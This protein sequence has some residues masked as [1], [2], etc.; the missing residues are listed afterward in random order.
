MGK[1]LVFKGMT[2][3]NPLQTVTFTE[4]GGDDYS[5]PVQA[6]LNKLSVSP[7][8]SHKDAFETFYQTLSTANL[9]D[10]ISCLYPM[11]GSVADCA[12]GLI[13]NDIVIPSGATYDQGIDL[14]NASGGFGGMEKGI[15]LFD[16][17]TFPP[18]SKSHYCMF[19]NYPKGWTTS[20]RGYAIVFANNTTRENGNAS[21]R[22]MGQIYGDNRNYMNFT[23]TLGGARFTDVPEGSKGVFG[24][25]HPYGSDNKGHYTYFNGQ[26]VA[27]ATNTFASVDNMG[28]IGIN[29][30][31]QFN[32]A[33]HCLN[34][35]ISMVTICDSY[36]F[37]DEEVATFTTAVNNLTSVIF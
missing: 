34:V 13:G 18:T 31:A 17:A 24:E 25:S 27:Q 9:W 20:Q 15:L 5:Q 26:R 37:T 11:Y 16:G 19:V 22:F 3:S 36:A 4:G 14:T 33:A 6:Y 28:K 7:T 10:K 2:I 8:K 32:Q 29:A 21:G 30:S 1:A 23:V 12:H 35:P